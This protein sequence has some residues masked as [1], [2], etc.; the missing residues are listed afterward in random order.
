MSFMP[1]L[2]GLPV[3]IQKALVESGISLQKVVRTIPNKRYVCS[4]IFENRA[5][6]A[7]IFIGKSATAYALRDK[8]GAKLLKQ[9]CILTPELLLSQGLEDGKHFLIYA[10]VE[11]TQ[12]AEE[13]WRSSDNTWRFLLM[14]QL[15]RT[16]AAHHQ[17]GLL[18]TDLHLK[19]F[20]VQSTSAVEMQI[21]TLDGDGI[22]Q[23][24]SFFSKSQCLKNLATLFSKFD[25]L[26]DVWIPSLF[27]L[28]CEQTGIV[29]SIEGK[30]NICSQTQ[31]IRHRV[32][33]GFAD[34]KVFR[35]CTDV[36]V[37]QK[38]SQFVAITSGFDLEKLALASLDQYLAEPQRNIKNGNT[39][40]VAKAELAGR[41]VVIKRYNIKSLWH[42]LSRAFRP[43]RAAK[44]WAN[45]FRLHILGVSTPKPIAL[46]EKRWWG[47]R[48]KAYF[49]SEYLD[50][51]DGYDYFTK[52]KNKKLQ[53][54]AIK[55]IV[56]LFYRMHLLK[57]SHGDMKSSNI[58][59]LDGN[60]YLIDLDSLRQHRWDY[61]ALK[62]HVQD[63]RRFMQ[64]WQA[65]SAL[66][67][68]FV[69][70]FSAVY[71]DHKALRLAGLIH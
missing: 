42:G 27:Q 34:K 32:A 12:N 66:Y 5:V 45:A 29:C 70:E 25:V 54:V 35:T 71:S 44:S 68:M 23:L 60:P 64:N 69:E 63:L 53:A 1:S 67:N 62:A 8:A 33:T 37:T 52:I 9:A 16:L 15:V 30:A 19:N 4:G 55:N 43:T 24:R 40:T 58:K 3:N 6:Y 13:V 31:K 36:N 20:L 11:N 59:V 61:F 18:Q 49:L 2:N 46:I 51:P 39:C 17:A 14:Q 7:K 10:A 47:L 57:L 38:F 41:H 21:Y 48:G 22:R 26:D 56:Y 50:A 65:Q 28:Y